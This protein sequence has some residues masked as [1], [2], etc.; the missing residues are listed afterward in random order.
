MRIVNMNTKISGLLITVIVAL[1]PAA[2]WS[3]PPS[4]MLK[5]KVKAARSLLQKKAQSGTAEAKKTDD[6]LRQVIEP[7]LDF[8]KMSENTLRVHWVSLQSQQ[9]AEFVSLFRALLFRSYLT[10]IRKADEDYSLLYESEEA[11]GRKAAAVTVIAQTSKAEI[12]LVFHVITNDGKLWIT[13][14]IVIDE[15][16]LVQNYREQFTRII[17]KDGYPALLQKMADKL[18]DLG[19]EIPTDITSVKAIK[20]AAVAPTEKPAAQKSPPQTT[21]KQK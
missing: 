6:E 18:V 8:Q 14:D 5:E 9:Q 7:A 10:R 12:E 2:A 11:K 19:G 16:S 4:D 15:V 13:E 20:P 21:P 1:L 17:K 3:G